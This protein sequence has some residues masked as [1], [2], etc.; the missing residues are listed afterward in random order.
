MNAAVDIP[1]DLVVISHETYPRAG[2][3]PDRVG[4]MV[5][6]YRDGG[7]DA[8]PPIEVV[9]V[10]NERYVLAEGAHRT[11]AARALGWTVLPAFVLEPPDGQDPIETAYLRALETAATAAKPLTRS[12]RR[13]AAER[14]LSGHPDW[15]DREIARRVGVS[16]QTVGRLRDAGLRKS[17]P[18]PDASDEYVAFVAAHRITDQLAR[19]L[20]KA[21][22]ARGI[23]D[24]LLR[25]MP[26]TLAQSLTSQF[27]DEAVVWAD[28]LKAWATD[29]LAELERESDR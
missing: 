28:R 9:R 24:L 25:R 7:R 2:L 14:L 17:P 19:G 15:P 6:L 12:E 27:G 4:E 5:Q 8:L 22:E 29:A 18:E 3:D 10:A 11:T 23:T 21:W 20:A 13:R 1:I 16:H 26:A